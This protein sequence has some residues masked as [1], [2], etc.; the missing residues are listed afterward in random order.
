MYY[1]RL[2]LFCLLC[3]LC[4]IAY[5]KI[6]KDTLTTAQGD[7]VIVS[8]DMTRSGDQ[9]TITFNGN[10]QKKLGRTNGSKYSDLSK[11]AVMF[12][13]RTGNFS[14]DVSILN[15]VPEA[16]M[17]PSN[18]GYSR[19]S[20]GFFVLQDSPSITFSVKGNMNVSI[21]VYLANHKKK[22][23]YDLFAKCKDMKIVSTARTSSPRNDGR[24]TTMEQTVTS[25][26]ELEADNT[27]LIKIPESVHKATILLAEADKLP[28]SESLVEE[29][30]FLR[31]KK[32]EIIDASLL[33][34]IESVIDRYEQKKKQLEDEAA[35]AT[36]AA[37]AA[38]EQKS[39]QAAQAAK[40]EA[41][42]IAAAQAAEAKKSEERSL[43]MIVGGVVLAIL[44]FIGNQFMQ[45]RRNAR[46]QKN[47]MDV[48]QSMAKK[49]ENEARRQAQNAA[50]R[51]QNAARNELRKRTPV[52]VNGKSKNISI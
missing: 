7:R 37:Q 21:P 28:F 14:R 47:M 49:A 39:A 1:L 5:P 42:S 36:Q 12:F 17:I 40:A 26:T 45:S 33:S 4:S 16:I 8:Y 22:G 19:S 6:V 48:Q 18:V 2:S 30:R 27:D 46:N 13:D 38:A 24:V 35:A 32:R 3:L 15:M 20:D 43:W 25:T 23:R 29:I 9:V 31:D 44:G 52:N 51:A 41:D 50:R 34:Q 10:P 11:I